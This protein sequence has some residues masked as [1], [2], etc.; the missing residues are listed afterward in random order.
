MA[1][2]QSP[3][4]VLQEVADFFASLPDGD[5]IL[6]FRPSEAVQQRARELLDRQQEGRITWD[7]E[8]EL[9]QFAHV[10]LLMRLVKAKLR[11]GSQP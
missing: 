3:S 9:D 7:E 1:T 8:R 2:V 6:S 11:A 5:E 4:R 10:E